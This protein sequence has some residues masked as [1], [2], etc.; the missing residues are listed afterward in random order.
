VKY[1]DIVF[2]D[3][4]QGPFSLFVIEVEDDRKAPKGRSKE[5]M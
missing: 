2:E 3:T 1:I 4:R 5:N